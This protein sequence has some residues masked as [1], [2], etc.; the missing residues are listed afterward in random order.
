MFTPLFSIGRKEGK[1]DVS[2]MYVYVTHLI[3]LP[4]QTVSFQ[5]LKI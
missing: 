4:L 3:T 1:K 5:F 2:G